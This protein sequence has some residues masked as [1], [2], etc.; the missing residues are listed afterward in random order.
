MPA[1]YVRAQYNSKMMRHFYSDAERRAF[2]DRWA[3][4]VPST[5]A[6]LAA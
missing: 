5:K 4:E 3:E 6:P 1:D 2:I